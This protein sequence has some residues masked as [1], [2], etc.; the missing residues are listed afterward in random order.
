MAHDSLLLSDQLKSD[1]RLAEAKHLIL[2]TVADHQN[3]MQLSLIHI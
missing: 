3:T 1:P 2:E